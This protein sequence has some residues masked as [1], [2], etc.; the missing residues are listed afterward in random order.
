MLGC[1]FTGFIPATVLHGGSKHS[2]ELLDAT[3]LHN[4]GINILK[5]IILLAPYIGSNRL[6]VVDRGYG[7]LKLAFILDALGFRYILM[8]KKGRKKKKTDS[9][10]KKQAESKN[11]K[12]PKNE[13]QLPYELLST[14]QE[15]GHISYT[16][17]EELNTVCTRWVDSKVCY[18]LSNCAGPEHI[19]DAYRYDKST[20]RTEARS[21]PYVVGLYNQLHGAIDMNDRAQAETGFNHKFRRWHQKLLVKAHMTCMISLEVYLGWLFPAFKKVTNA[22]RRHCV[23][24]AMLNSIGSLR[25]DAVKTVDDRQ[26][27]LMI[28]QQQKKPGMPYH[29]YHPDKVD[30]KG[31]PKLVKRKVTFLMSYISCIET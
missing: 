27:R 2:A 14:S 30:K 17:C 25:K 4:L 16:Y 12:Q 22:K 23:A 5:V 20:K 11:S 3:G 10:S 9:K 24:D 28:K 29:N 31:K 21:M 7:T 6:V 1:P 13:P 15:R 19:I 8:C 26:I 18:L